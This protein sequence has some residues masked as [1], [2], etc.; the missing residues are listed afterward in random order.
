MSGTGNTNLPPTGGYTGQAW[1]LTGG[2]EFNQTAFLV[3]QIIA[4]KAFAAMVQVMSVSNAGDVAASGTVSVQPMVD[5]IDG[6]GNRMPHGIIYNIPYMRVQGGTNAVI[7]DPQVGDIGLAVICDRDI[8][9]VKATKKRSGPG[10]R[11]QNDWSDGCYIG[12]FLNAVPVNYI[13]FVGPD[14]N[15]VSGGTLSHN[16]VNIGSTHVHALPGGGNTLGPH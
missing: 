1:A 4:G 5:Q 3:R 10:S 6:L 9:T 2:S 8:S 14:I 15:I 16:G 7:I 11:R 12:G 13:Q